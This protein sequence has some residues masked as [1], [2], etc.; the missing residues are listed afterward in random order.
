MYA[1]YAD[2]KAYVRANKGGNYFVADLDTLAGDD[3]SGMGYYGVWEIVVIGAK[4]NMK[5]R[6][7]TVF[8]GYAYVAGSTTVSH[9][10]PISG[11]TAAQSGD[12][13]VD[14]GV[15]AGEG[16]RSISGDYLQVLGR[17]GT[18]TNTNH[19]RSLGN[20][21]LTGGF[22]NSNVDTGSAKNPDRKSVV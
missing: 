1:A 2:V 21:T 15:M 20:S 18:S 3:T 9:Q 4:P 22:F 13:N 16:D 12:I 14:I 5:W 19:Y 7:I 6:D 11:F 8:D 17:G 10:L